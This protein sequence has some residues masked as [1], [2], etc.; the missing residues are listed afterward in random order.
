[1]DFLPLMLRV[2]AVIAPVILVALGGFFWAKFDRNFSSQKLG[3]IALYVGTPGLLFSTLLDTDIDN[4][5]LGVCALGAALYIAITLAVLLGLSRMTNTPIN[6]NATGLTF[7]NWGNLGMPICLFA[8]GQTGLTVAATFFAVSIF[9]QFTLGW[10]ISAGSWPIKSIVG[11]PLLWAL[12]AALGLKSAHIMPPQWLLDTTR[13]VGGAGIPCMLLALGGGIARMRPASLGKGFALTAARAALGLA[14]GFV[15]VTM[16]PFPQP[17]Q[18]IV[19][20]ISVMPVAVFN[21]ILAE[22]TGQDA[23]QVAGYVVASTAL[24]L[25]ILPAALALL[26]PT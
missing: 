9:V 24:S 16:L 22:K 23:A 3:D 13:L 2:G 8:F 12:A 1:M 25:L 21:Y 5:L 26:M 19:L 20:T 15:L 10:R 17:L 6:P 7:N 14:V 4:A 11:Q 18:P